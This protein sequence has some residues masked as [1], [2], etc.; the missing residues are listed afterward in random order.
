MQIPQSAR[1]NAVL[2]LGAPLD[3][4][5]YLTE[6]RQGVLG[7]LQDRSKKESDGIGMNRSIESIQILASASNDRPPLQLRAQ[8]AGWG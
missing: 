4:T 2:E 3:L 1:P 6:Y 7:E 5:E 8:C